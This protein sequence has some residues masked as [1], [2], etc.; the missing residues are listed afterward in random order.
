M[1][2]SLGLLILVIALAFL[3]AREAI[4][5]IQKTVYPGGFPVALVLDIDGVVIDEVSFVRT[6]AGNASLGNKLRKGD[7]IIE[8]DGDK[9]SGCDELVETIEGGEGAETE[10]TLI[11]GG[12]T[13]KVSVTPYIESDSGLY[14]LGVYIRDTISGVGTVTYVKENGCFCALGHKI[15]DSVA[16]F[17]LPISGGK[18]FGCELLGVEKGKRNLPGELRAAIKGGVIGEIFSNTDRGVLGKLYGYDLKGDLVP[19]GERTAASPGKAYILTTIDDKTDAYEVEI[20]KA[21]PQSIATPKGM[22]IRVTDKRLLNVSGGIV[23]GMSGSPLLQGGKLIG[24]VTHVLIND[25]TKGYAIY[26]DWLVG[27]K[28]E[29]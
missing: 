12:K 7:A 14:K 21:I 16:G 25:P 17:D 15:I 24:A 5:A 6:A 9:V 23:Q 4:Y 27:I 2:K 28:E 8:I 11:R 13:I 3:P 20:I 19:L 26:S 1:K 29:K 22:L 10:L 18:V